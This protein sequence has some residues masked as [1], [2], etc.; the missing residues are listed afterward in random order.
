LAKPGDAAV[1]A[2]ESKAKIRNIFR[3]VI[4]SLLYPRA[5]VVAHRDKP[6]PADEIADMINLRALRDCVIRC[7]SSQNGQVSKP[8]QKASVKAPARS[9]M[10]S[11]N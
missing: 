6:K 11:V 8:E 4:C 1:S 9:F 5:N 3:K 10:A 2:L 7:A